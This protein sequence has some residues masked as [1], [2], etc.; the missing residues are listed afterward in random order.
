[1]Y[2][3]RRTSAAIQVRPHM[4]IAYVWIEYCTGNTHLHFLQLYYSYFCLCY[5]AENADFNQSYYI[6]LFVAIIS[7]AKWYRVMR[8]WNFSTVTY[9]NTYIPV[10][11]LHVSVTI[12]CCS[13]AG[14]HCVTLS[15]WAKGVDCKPGSNITSTPSNHTWNAVYIDGG[16]QLVDCHWATRYVQ[17]DRKKRDNIVYEWVTVLSFAYSA[18]F[19]GWSIYAILTEK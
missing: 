17:A 9:L 1:M 5:I 13:H 14:L 7:T 6:G 12:L 3:I 8:T 15:G 4:M 19:T 10:A 18:E 16:W 2:S 11:V